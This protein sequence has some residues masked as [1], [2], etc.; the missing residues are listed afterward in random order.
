MRIYLRLTKN[1]RI[2]PFNY[3]E[4]LTGTIHKWIGL[5]NEIHGKVGN[6]SFSW[7]Q[8]TIANKN[9]IDLKRDAYFFISSLNEDFIKRIIKNILKDPTMFN[10]IRVFD[11]QIKETPQ[12]GVEERFLMASPVLLKVKED[13]K[14]RHVTLEDKDFEE[15]L[16]ANFKRKLEKAGLTSEGIS[17]KLNPETSFRQTKLVTYKKIK[18][19][20]SFAPIVIK[21]SPEQI[22]FAWEVGLGN[23]TG[24]GFGALK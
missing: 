18:N 12:F 15:I 21:G 4:L 9:G 16:T 2:V 5:D 17:I 6:F 7:I 22:A 20:T 8:N 14:I 24:I 11:I 19:K 3:Q 23:S 10:G 13:D 1:N